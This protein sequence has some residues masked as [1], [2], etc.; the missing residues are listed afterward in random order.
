MCRVMWKSSR[1]PF[2]L[3]GC[4]IGTRTTISEAGLNIEGYAAGWD[5]DEEY[6]FALDASGLYLVSL[7]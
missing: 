1:A 4:K 5:N 6:D 3:E 2:Y 7:Q